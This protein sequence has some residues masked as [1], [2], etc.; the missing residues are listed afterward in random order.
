MEAKDVITI[1]AV[2]MGPIFAV[3]AQKMIEYFRDKKNRRLAIFKT[4]MST[5]GERLNRDHV[6]ALNMIDIEFDGRRDTWF[7]RQNKKE[8]GVTEAWKKYKDHLDSRKN[9]DLI[10]SWI[11]DGDELFI[12]LLYRMSRALGYDYDEVQIKRD[13]Y[14]P[15]AHASVEN[16]QLDVLEGLAKVLRHEQSIPMG[17]TYFPNIAQ[18]SDQQPRDEKSDAKGDSEGTVSA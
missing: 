2:I 4:L 11:K 8:K 5:R 10:S 14:R 1:F 13:C 17:I 7:S 12:G 18:Q 16:A 15:E 9:Y 6:Q 3:Q